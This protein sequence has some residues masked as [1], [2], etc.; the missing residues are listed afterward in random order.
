MTQGKEDYDVYGRIKYYQCNIAECLRLC[1]ELLDRSHL[2]EGV[3][4]VAELRELSRIES[5]TTVTFH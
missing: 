3:L 4:S 5:P 2:N 1:M